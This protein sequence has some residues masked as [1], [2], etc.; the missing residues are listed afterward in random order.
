VL[1]AITDR[2]AVLAR[3]REL[4]EAGDPQLAL[5]VVDVLAL[6]PGEEPEVVEARALK[7]DICNALAVDAESFVSQSLYVSTARII[8]EGAS[9]PTGVR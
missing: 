5:H 7:A 3:A 1:S 4:L 2:G 8:A 9:K 6:A